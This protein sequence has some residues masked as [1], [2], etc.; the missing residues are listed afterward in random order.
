MEAAEVLAQL[1]GLP[2]PLGAV[3]GFL[4]EVAQGGALPP[5][6]Q[7]LPEELGRILEGLV[8]AVGGKA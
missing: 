2:E 1:A 6:P 5:V 4:H 7:G 8:A 3:G